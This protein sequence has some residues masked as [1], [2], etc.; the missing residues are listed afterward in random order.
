MSAFRLL[1]TRESKASTKHG[2]TSGMKVSPFI[3]SMKRFTMPF[4]KLAHVCVKGATV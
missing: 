4:G 3:A 1:L 2:N